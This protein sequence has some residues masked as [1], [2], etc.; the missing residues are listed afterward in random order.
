[1]EIKNKKRSKNMTVFETPFH[2]MTNDREPADAKLMKAIRFIVAEE[3]EATQLYMKLAC[4][5]TDNK[6]AVEVLK[7]IADEEQVQVGALL[8]LL[9]EPGPEK[10]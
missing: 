5:V 2:G 1:V 3:N 10:T 6:L 7:D 4:Q 8:R 9:R